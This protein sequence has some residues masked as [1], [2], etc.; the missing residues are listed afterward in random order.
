MSYSS[1]VVSLPI[2]SRVDS[3]RFYRATLELE[4]HGDLGPDGIP[5]PL[6][7]ELN[8]GLRIML[9]PRVGFSWVIGD[10]EVTAAD[11]SE[12]QVVLT[13]SDQREVGKFIERARAAGA[14]I[15]CE[16]AHQPWGYVG[17]FADPDGHL[18]MIRAGTRG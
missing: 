17:V 10:R 12:C 3:C 1:V 11:Q 5:E 6:Q 4:P 15:V 16:P 18:W 14:E 7:F 9:I 2:E 13:C 8:H